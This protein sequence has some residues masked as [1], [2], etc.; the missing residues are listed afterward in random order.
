M[1][2]SR[3]IINERA[4]LKLIDYAIILFLFYGISVIIG[5]LEMKKI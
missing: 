1:T 4:S 3:K 2:K 5:N